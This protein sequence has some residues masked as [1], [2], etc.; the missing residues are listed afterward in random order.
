MHIHRYIHTYDKELIAHNYII[1][2]GGYQFGSFTPLQKQIRL[3]TVN[4]KKIK[5]ISMNYYLECAIICHYETPPFFS[6]H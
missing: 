1:N 3:N 5:R 2:W 4:F 6:L